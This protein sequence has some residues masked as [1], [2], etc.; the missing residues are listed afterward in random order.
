MPYSWRGRQPSHPAACRAGRR[1]MF[2]AYQQCCRPIGR[3]RRLAAGEDHPD[4]RRRT[5]WRGWPRGAAAWREEAAGRERVHQGHRGTGRRSPTQRVVLG[6]GV[7]QRQHD[8]LAVLGAQAARLGHRHAGEGVVGLRDLDALG[9][10]GRAGREHH[11]R[12]LAHR[13]RLPAGDDVGAEHV[14]HGVGLV[15]QDDRQVGRRLLVHVGSR[16][17]AE[18]DARRCARGARRARGRAHRVRRHDPRPEAH[19]RQPDGDERRAVGQREVDGVAGADAV[20]GE[21]AGAATDDGVELAVGPLGHLARRALE[22]QERRVLAAVDG[23]GPQLV[24]GDRLPRAAGGGRHEN[25]A[26]RSVMPP[27]WNAVG[28]SRSVRSVS[29]SRYRSRG[30]SGSSTYAVRACQMR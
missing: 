1:V 2:I 18:A 19:R 14:E 10:A 20:G 9:L 15:D 12:P 25:A 28:R 29:H 22:P 7:E 17:R 11:R 27:V 13:Y 4:R 3:R 21:Q 6:V 16:R 26:V 23:A 5:G 24:E 30:R 8:E